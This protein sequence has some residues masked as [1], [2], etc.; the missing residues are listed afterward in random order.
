MITKLL[1][2]YIVCLEQKKQKSVG[3]VKMFYQISPGGPKASQEGQDN[4]GGGGQ[5]QCQEVHEVHQEKVVAF[6]C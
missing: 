6:N 1:L 4:G 5:L 2:N 3:F